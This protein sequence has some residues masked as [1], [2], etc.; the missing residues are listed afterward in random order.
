MNKN[1]GK[2][3]GLTYPRTEGMQGKPVNGMILMD[4]GWRWLVSS[5]TNHNDNSK[6][7]LLE[8]ENL[9]TVKNLCKMIKVK[10]PNLIFLM[11]TKL[12]HRKME[13]KKLDR[14]S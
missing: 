9:Q 10:K 5:P 6:L 3:R 4:W 13:N 12:H 8:F 2:P 1:K 7:E 11:E 14:I